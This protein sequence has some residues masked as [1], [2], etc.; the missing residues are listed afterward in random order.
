L[1]TPRR[2]R[3]V[4]S[5]TP[6][7]L[8]APKRFLTA[9]ITRWAWCFSPSKYSTVSTMCSSAFGT[10]EGAVLGDVADEE[11]RDVL[12]LGRE[13]QLR[14][15]LTDLADA[16]R[17]GLELQREHRLHRVDDD[18]GRAQ[19]CDLLENALEAGLG[20]DVERRAARRRAARRAT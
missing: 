11:R 20:E 19:A 1:A 2:P 5:K 8:T 9:R 18:E 15:R 10:G 3:P 6:S 17:R 13:Q 16:A 12:P 7:S 4:I 14:R